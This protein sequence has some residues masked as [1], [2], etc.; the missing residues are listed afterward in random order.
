VLKNIKIDRDVV[1]EIVDKLSFTLTGAQ[2][3]VLKNI[4]ENIHD[5]KP[6]MRLLQ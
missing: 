5:P 6:M 2:K 4:I 1:R 3:R